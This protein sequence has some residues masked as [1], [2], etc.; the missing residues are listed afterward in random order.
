MEVRAETR[1][2]W[3]IPNISVFDMRR[4]ISAH[5]VHALFSLNQQGGTCLDDRVDFIRKDEPG[6]GIMVFS[7]I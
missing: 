5:N 4:I 6:V 2:N 1:M 7:Q 3:N